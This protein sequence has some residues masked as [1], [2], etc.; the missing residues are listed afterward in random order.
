VRSGARSRSRRGEPYRFARFAEATAAVCQDSWSS[1]EP[2]ER[3][4]AALEAAAREDY[5]ERGR[6]VNSCLRL[7]YEMSDVGFLDRVDASRD[8]DWRS[9]STSGRARRSS[10]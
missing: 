7:T 8:M 4:R 10:G 2:E 3:F 5:D 6:L 9:R 1:L